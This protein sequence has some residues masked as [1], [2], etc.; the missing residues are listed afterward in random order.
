MTQ[1]NPPATLSEEEKFIEE[2]S[3]MSDIEVKAALVKER[4]RRESL[5]EQVDY[6]SQYAKCSRDLQNGHLHGGAAV[7][8]VCFNEER[9]LR[10]EATK[11]FQQSCD[12]V[13]DFA[14][15]LDRARKERAEAMAAVRANHEWHQ[16]YDDYDGYP[17]SDLC[18]TNCHALGISCGSD[19]IH[20][21]ELEAAR[22]SVIE[23]SAKA[24][25]I[26]HYL[27]EL[28]EAGNKYLAKRAWE[29]FKQERINLAIAVSKAGEVLR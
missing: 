20:K 22:K 15:K 21:S 28:V 19:Y 18:E 11:C 2:M 23:V 26:A 17:E 6:L 25:T 13:K 12:D 5:Q 24:I 4:N 9:K 1:P 27:R 7:C 3:K 10:E 29:D 16:A 8:Q 14:Q